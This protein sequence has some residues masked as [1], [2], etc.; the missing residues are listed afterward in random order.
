[1]KKCALELKTR[2]MS[3]TVHLVATF[4]LTLIVAALFYNQS[5]GLNLLLSEILVVGYLFFSKRLPVKSAG[6]LFYTVALLISG[7]F[8][9]INHSV[10]AVFMHFVALAMFAGVMAY[11]SWRSPLLQ[12]IHGVSSFFLS[13]VVFLKA[14]AG[15]GQR[16]MN[17]FAWIWRGRIFL[18]PLVVVM[19]FVLIY[20]GA[21]PV[22]ASYAS[23][24]G[25]YLGKGF[26]FLFSEIDGL[27]VATLLVS[28]I[29]LNMVLW[30]SVNT[31]LSSY[32]SHGSDSLQRLRRRGMWPVGMASLNHELKGGVVLLAVLNA[33]L[34][35]VNILDVHGVWFGFEWRGQY[36]KQY[37]HDGTWLLI[38][39]ILLS[40]AVVLWYFRGNLHFHPRNGWLRRLAIVWLVQNGVLALSVAIRTFYYIEYFSL[41]YKRIGVFIFLVLTFYGLYTVY[42][43]VELRQSVFWLVR[44]NARAWFVVLLLSSFV[45]WDVVIARYNFAHS[46]RSF[47][48]LDFMS[49]LSDNALPYLDYPLPE[50]QR[51]D[52]VQKATFR[53]R[54]DFLLPEKYHETI[55]QRKAD[56]L[57]RWESKDWRAWNWAE[58]KAARDLRKAGDATSL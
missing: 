5:F 6:E 42:R 47:L 22:F 48:H 8:T 24:V 34:L 57:K 31:F 12:I 51:I 29:L 19:L 40:M 35:F 17:P 23:L 4:M 38:F 39:S 49:G 27:L 55:G 10:F 52:S 46:H 45:N 16:Q 53:F 58:Y 26:D 32:D 44:S 41:A 9:V 56:F 2:N 3:K 30:P 14:L 54:D 37:V 20:S 50:L 36:L 18:I 21:N 11:G 7:L 15:S 25:D 28:L 13:Q 33:I 1:M 43:K